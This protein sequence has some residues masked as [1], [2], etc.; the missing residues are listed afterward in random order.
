MDEV[1]KIFEIK[2]PEK[3]FEQ[4]SIEEMV[5]I[6]QKIEDCESEIKKLSE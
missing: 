1:I 4:V 5:T 2:I 3:D 6:N